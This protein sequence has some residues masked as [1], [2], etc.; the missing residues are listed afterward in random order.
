MRYTDEQEKILASDAKTI[1]VRASAGTGKTFVMIEKIARLLAAGVPIENMLVI[2]FTEKAATEMR[3]RL[4]KK[5]DASDDPLLKKAKRSIANADISTLHAY[6]GKMVRRYAYLIGTR[7]DRVVLLPNDA[8]LIRARA[9][10]QTMHAYYRD[11]N[12][13]RLLRALGA[14]EKR[15]KDL[16]LAQDRFLWDGSD[17]KALMPYT[18]ARLLRDA[19]VQSAKKTLRMAIESYDEMLFHLP[20]G[21]RAEQMKA[22]RVMI[23]Q[24]METVG[25]KD[26]VRPEFLRAKP[27]KDK[28]LATFLKEKRDKIKKT[29]DAIEIPNIAFLQ[30]K[31]ELKRFVLTEASRLARDFRARYQDA[32]RAMHGMD[33][34]DMEHDFL[35]LLENERALRTIT[36]LK[37]YVFFDEYQDANPIQERIIRA[38]SDAHLFLVGD[39]KQSIYVFRGSEPELFLKREREIE[40]GKTS[41][42]VFSLTQNFRSEPDILH[43]VNAVFENAMTLKTAGIDYRSGHA[44]RVSGTGGEI[45]ARTLDVKFSGDERMKARAI[46]AAKTILRE[47][48]ERPFGEMAILMRTNDFYTHARVFDTYGIPY[49]FERDETDYAS[50]EPTLYHLIEHLVYPMEPMSLAVALRSFAGGC[51]EKDLYRISKSEGEDFVRSYENYA[52]EDET[53]ERI[54]AFR[55]FTKKWRNR[56]AEESLATFIRDFIYESGYLESLAETGTSRTLD[57]VMAFA[58]EAALFDEKSDTGIVGFLL[59]IRE[60]LERGL[61]TT[62]SIETEAT[63]DAVTF[64]TMHKSKGL[65]FP[66]VILEHLDKSYNLRDVAADA[67]ILSRIGSSIPIYVDGERIDDPERLLFSETMKDRQRAEE[68]RLFYVATTRAKQKLILHLEGE[69]AKKSVP[70]AMQDLYFA[71]GTLPLRSI[72]ETVEDDTVPIPIPRESIVQTP[73]EKIE[74]PKIRTT[75]KTTVTKQTRGTMAHFEMLHKDQESPYMEIGTRLHRIVEKLPKNPYEI[76]RYLADAD[77]DGLFT[78]KMRNWYLKKIALLLEDG[79]VHHEYAFTMRKT[80][81]DETLYI[82]GQIDL[83]IERDNYCIVVDFKSDHTIDPARYE[84]QL[85][86]Y[87]EAVV[88]AFHKPTIS[89]VYWL[90][91][92]ELTSYGEMGINH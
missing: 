64:L 30:E 11:K 84:S 91:F 36:G 5:C 58:D 55:A 54:R 78:E 60:R 3:E 43:F 85:A 63:D 42:E 41:G 49:R 18:D 12:A 75:R 40:T 19:L 76:D 69:G 89:A 15:V 71:S 33:F 65:E 32:K 51:D 59:E 66:L 10:D 24:F 23:E 81:D 6:A 26:E 28:E 62:T 80:K 46:R 1:L 67:L 74:L 17:E 50:G 27:V 4:R 87:K 35:M 29:I 38:F 57:A 79:R 92:G 45:E 16:I 20:D 39:V 37:T 83:L 52:C 70:N 21:P 56:M 47:R 7:P 2:T 31:L 44:F 25:T 34:D 22:E 68:A 90:R 82:D 72:H 48:E 9:V 53:M 77:P 13:V 61:K 86:L 73:R 14:D 88:S 8:E